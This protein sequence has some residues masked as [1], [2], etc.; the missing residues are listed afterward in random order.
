MGRGS[1]GAV[2]GIRP[3]MKEQARF[4]VRCNRLEVLDGFGSA[5]VLEANW[6][7]SVIIKDRGLMDSVGCC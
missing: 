1:A 6:R 2:M 5:G 7:G 4:W 3:I